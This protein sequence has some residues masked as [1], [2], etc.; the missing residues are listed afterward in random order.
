MK[1]NNRI[2][3]WLLLLGLVFLQ[4]GCEKDLY[5]DQIHK[6]NIVFKTVSLKD[7]LLKQNYQ[8]MK[9]VNHVK[10]K[11][12]SLNNKMV[13]DSINNF[14]FDDEK[15]FYIQDNQKETYTF[16]V[17]RLN[18]NDD[19]KLEN[20]VFKKNQMGEFETFLLKYDISKNQL[21]DSYQ[22]NPN[23]R[24]NNL[25]E[26]KEITA[27]KIMTMYNGCRYVKVSLCSG[28]P[29]NCGGGW[30]G[31]TYEI[32]CDDE[33]NDAVAG[34]N[35]STIGEAIST[36]PNG[37]VSSSSNNPCLKL[38]KLKSD[39]VF[40]QKMVGL[41]NAAEQWSF[42]KM[43]VIYDDPTPNDQ[44]SQTDN[45]DYEDFQGDINVPEANYSGNTSMQ[46]IIHSHYN[47]KVSIFSPGDLL[48]LYEKMKLPAITDDF[49]I[50]L[51]TSEG[52]AYILQIQDR[53]AFIEFGNTYLSTN[54]K[55]EKFMND[56]YFQSYGI[57]A[58]TPPA[59]AEKKFLKMMNEL[60]AG[61]SLASSNFTPNSPSSTTLFSNWTKKQYN[62]LTDS[63]TP[64]NCN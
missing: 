33:I 17:Y 42:E 2:L 23:Q 50:G 1:K 39:D 57:E 47:G 6:E 59:I 20:I 7:N 43:H 29:W 27:N 53:Q 58:D 51:V 12:Y 37:G 62:D 61:I 24:N 30:C 25:I 44:I 49:F 11:H 32:V 45:Y 52:T 56:T 22:T 40:K 8:L 4:V 55:F 36:S 63:V 16:R 48:D 38:D 28:D 14:Y 26:I 60:G 41:K 18:T 10:I 46:G 9:A 19:Q 31:F 34:Y 15:G 13:Y 64:T 54:G 21:D 3:N 35:E 5:E